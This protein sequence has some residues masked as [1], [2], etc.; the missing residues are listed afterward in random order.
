MNPPQ[1]DVS[2][3][4]SAA[5]SDPAPSGNGAEARRERQR[6]EARRSILDA[7]EALIAESD[8][9]DFAIRA[10][11]Q[12]CGYSA[13]TI[14]H[15]FGDKD[16]LL[17]ALLEER[18][19][20]LFDQLRTVELSGDPLG[21]LRRLSLAFVEFGVARPPFY[22][23]ISTVS[24]TGR[25]RMPPSMEKSLEILQGPMR[26]LAAAGRLRNGDSELA[27]QALW[28]LVH[29]LA[30][31]RIARPDHP[32][33]AD[34]ARRSIDAMLGGLIASPAGGGAETVS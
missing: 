19:A 2:R 7:T 20:S 1:D 6:Q 34:L 21:D 17:D 16:G 23:L 27:E 22:R 33:A 9:D 11:A 14:Y 5:A 31:L 15:Y 10:L 29:G 26:R 18:F 3:A 32:W 24:R 4:R 8:G 30:S 28:A 25:D 12:R 13:P